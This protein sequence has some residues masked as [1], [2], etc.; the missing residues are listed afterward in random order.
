MSLC[1]DLVSSNFARAAEDPT[2]AGVKIYSQAHI[3]AFIV[4]IIM[5]IS[6]IVVSIANGII[7]I[8]ISRLALVFSFFVIVFCS[9]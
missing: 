9:V 3:M 1:V 6:I 7:I 4:I 2:T 8:I 5:V